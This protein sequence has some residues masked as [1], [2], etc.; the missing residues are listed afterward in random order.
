MRRRM[1]VGG[2]AV[3]AVLGLAVV[4]WAVE[5]GH[6]GH[7]FSGRGHREM[8]ARVLALLDNE[9]FRATMNLTDEQAGRLREIVVNAEKSTIKTRAAL[10]VNGID[11]R[12]MLR[13]DNPDRSAVLKKVQDISNLR[14]EL[15]KEHIEAL[16]AAK[17]VLTPEQQKKIRQ[18]FESR[19]GRGFMHGTMMEH[20]GMPG[21]GMEHH[22]MPG[23]GAAPTNPP[24]PP[25]E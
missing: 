14:G 9:H 21:P 18:F 4:G 3:A 11:L 17:S 19:H 7:G 24:Q 8:A 20:H 12:E 13:A 10:E 23:P 5:R 6:W 16:L 22:G 1:I 2:I 15:M 25:S